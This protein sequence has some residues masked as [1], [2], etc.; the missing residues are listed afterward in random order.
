[1]HR[2]TGVSEVFPA[3]GETLGNVLKSKRGSLTVTDVSLK[4]LH[5]LSLETFDLHLVI[6]LYSHFPV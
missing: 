6:L 4:V 1:M 3:V 2:K 5:S